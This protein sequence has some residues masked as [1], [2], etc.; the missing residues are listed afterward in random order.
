MDLEQREINLKK[1]LRRA[2]DE[3]KSVGE[4]LTS[5]R[6]RVAQLVEEEKALRR[7][8][9][10]LLLK[11]GQHIARRDNAEMEIR[12]L[13]DELEEAK[14]ILA[15]ELL[16]ESTDSKGILP[17]RFQ[18]SDKYRRSDNDD[19]KLGM[20]QIA[21]PFIMLISVSNPALQDSLKPIV[22]TATKA[23]QCDLQLAQPLSLKPAVQ[24][25]YAPFSFRFHFRSVLTVVCGCTDR[26][27]VLKAR[28]QYLPPIHKM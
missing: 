18:D 22:K 19:L 7:D 4:Q 25:L 6:A 3:K 21:P 9:D 17:D 12:Q 13:Q 14:S 10:Y 26:M 5:E 24:N 28:S 23:V 8:Y 11:T 1:T 15:Y 2:Q 16:T 20:V 27:K